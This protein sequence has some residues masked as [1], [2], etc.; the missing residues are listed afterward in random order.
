M[1]VYF[2]TSCILT[3][4]LL[5]DGAEQL[6]ELLAALEEPPAYSDFG[7]GECVSGVGLRVR[8]RLLTATQGTSVVQGLHELLAKWRRL[9]VQSQDVALG[10]RYLNDFTLGLRL[11]DALHI[12]VA[13]RL[14]L[15]LITADRRQLAAA[16]ALGVVAHNPFDEG[17]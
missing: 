6:I 3:V 7:F 13:E 5:D 12:A 1:N 2:D 16:R 10:T 17:A 9:Q 14:N 15:Q 4:A 11:P 8:Q